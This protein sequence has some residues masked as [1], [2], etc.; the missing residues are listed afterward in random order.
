MVK[1]PYATSTAPFVQFWIRK[2]EG[3][4][5]AIAKGIIEILDA[6][7]EVLLVADDWGLYREEE[8]E[9]IL[10]IRRGMGETRSVIDAPGHE[11]KRDDEN[12][13]QKLIQFFL[14]AETGWSAYVYAFPSKTTLFFWERDIIDLWSQ[15]RGTVEKFES[16]LETVK[17]K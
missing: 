4:L 16:F 17:R 1:R 12:Y 6:D 5:A 8:M 13:R 11:M 10:E 3:D 9:Q 7:D 14:S 2:S 15:R